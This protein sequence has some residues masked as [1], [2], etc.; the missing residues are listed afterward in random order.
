MVTYHPAGR[1]GGRLVTALR[2]EPKTFNPVMAVDNPSRTVIRRMTADLIHID[3]HTQDVEPGLAKSWTISEDGR[4][5]ILNL[6]KGVHFSDGHLF[7]AG[8]V[9]FTFQ[10]YLDIGSPNR[11]LL[12]IDGEPIKVRRLDSHT[13]EFE[14]AAPYAVGVRLFDSIAILPEHILGGKYVKKGIA[15]E[16]SVATPA[17]DIVGLGPFRL[18]EYVPGERCVLER[19]PHYWKADQEGAQLP[20]FDEL[21]FLLVPSEDAQV[22]R[23]QTGATDMID[24]LS[25]QNFSSLG[26]NRSDEQA[27]AD[28]GPGSEYIFLMFNQNDLGKSDLPEVS[29][30]QGWFKDLRFR[31]AVSYVVDRQAIVRL[32]YHGRASSQSGIETPGNKRWVNKALPKPEKSI[33]LAKAELKKSNFSWDRDGSLVDADGREVEFTI[34][35]SSGNAQRLKIGT[36]IQEDIGSLGIGVEV[37]SMELR[38]VIG[39]VTRSLDYEACILSLRGGD[40]DPNGQANVLLST[41][42]LHLWNLNQIEPATD[43]EAEIDRLMKQQLLELDY[44]LRKQHYDRVQSIIAEQLPFI[45]LVG[46]H[47]LVGAKQGLGNFQPT[48]LDHSTLWNVESLF[49]TGSRPRK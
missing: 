40:V 11:D 33:E 18:R 19:N 6:R 20:Y 1:R 10:V 14:L 46:P 41:G 47:V 16:W 34:A 39:R 21:V 24:G 7:D 17:D 37:V 43:W 32:V 12:I 29:A 42:Q 3:R 38:S 36:I 4:R 27:L 15:D 31:R 25:A 28:L 26:R 8:D 44:S 5:Y 9:L 35:V 13:V 30:K 2:A 23:F 49:W 22:V 48:V 45:F